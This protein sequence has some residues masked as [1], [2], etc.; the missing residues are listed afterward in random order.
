MPSEPSS[1]RRPS[2]VGIN[3]ASAHNRRLRKFSF[4]TTPSKSSIIAQASRVSPRKPSVARSL[5]LLSSHQ[6]G[7]E[8]SIKQSNTDLLETVQSAA[9]ERWRGLD[10][11]L[12]ARKPSVQAPII[13]GK[14]DIQVY[15]STQKMLEGVAIKH[16]TPAR[17]CAFH[18]PHISPL[19]SNGHSVDSLTSIHGSQYSVL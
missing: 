17:L 8:G 9:Q 13:D 5:S 1:P 12:P 11:R 6:H 7:S 15:A 19:N 2:H 4:L 14:P 16:G 18:K 3:A 10:A